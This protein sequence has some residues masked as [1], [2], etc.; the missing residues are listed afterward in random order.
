MA[1]PHM[2]ATYT[3]RRNVYE[4]TYTSRRNKEIELRQTWNQHANYFH[5]NDA[6]A[7][8]KQQWESRA[9]FQNR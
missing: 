1:L 2:P 8:K 9:S 4:T 5:V 3:A 6:E 7:I